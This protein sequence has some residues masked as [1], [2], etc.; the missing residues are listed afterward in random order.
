MAHERGGCGWQV[1]IAIQT[2]L[3]A[4]S[5]PGCRLRHYVE[6]E[7]CRAGCANETASSPRSLT[8]HGYGHCGTLEKQDSGRHPTL[9]PGLIKVAAWIRSTS[10]SPPFFATFFSACLGSVLAVP[11]FLCLRWLFNRGWCATE[12][13]CGVHVAMSPGK[14]TKSEITCQLLR[15]ERSSRASHGGTCYNSRPMHD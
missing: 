2:A 3:C 5:G 13:Q 1:C 4:L 15:W 11:R 14:V 7:P 8:G 9:R 10:S 6:S 12:D